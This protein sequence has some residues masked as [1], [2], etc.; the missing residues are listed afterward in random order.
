[1][2]NWK[3]NWNSG[4][5]YKRDDVVRLNGKSYVCIYTHTSNNSF[6]T[7]L[8]AILAGSN[9]PVP[10]PRWIVMTEGQYFA[11]N[12]TPGNDYNIGD[13]VL[14]N[15]VLWLCTVPHNS[16]SFD[17]D[18][19]N[20]TTFANGISFLGDW[21]SRYSLRSRRTCCIRRQLI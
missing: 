18:N 16:T 7:D 19:S 4:V 21:A 3:G 15:G 13:I 11:G 5:D 14:F 2:Y 8:N 17:I 6:R 20:F 9:P 10:Q 12:Y 1:M